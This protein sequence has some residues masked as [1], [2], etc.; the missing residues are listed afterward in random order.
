MQGIQQIF[1]QQA[2]E[3]QSSIDSWQSANQA[4]MQQ[5]YQNGRSISTATNDSINDL[6]PPIWNQGS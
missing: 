4:Y 2:I 3:K 1:R 6:K 5:H